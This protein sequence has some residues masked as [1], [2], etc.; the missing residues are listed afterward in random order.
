[1]LFNFETQGSMY[2]IENKTI[3]YV[4]CSNLLYVY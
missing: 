4:V 3:N 2:V 1:M